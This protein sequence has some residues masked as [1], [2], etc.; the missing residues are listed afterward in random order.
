M[1]TVELRVDWSRLVYSDL[2]LI[3]LHDVQ[4]LVLE[5]VALYS[6]SLWRTDTIVFVKLNKPLSQISPPPPWNVLEI[7][8]PRRGFIE[9]LGRRAVLLQEYVHTGGGRPVGSI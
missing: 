2:F 4:V 1:T 7:I 5:L 8:K 6:S 9:D 3:P